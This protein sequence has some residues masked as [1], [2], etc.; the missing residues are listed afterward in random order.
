MKICVV[1]S[2]AL[3]QDTGQIQRRLGSVQGV[4]QSEWK[5]SEL[6]I[7][8]LGMQGEEKLQSVTHMSEEN[9]EEESI[10]HI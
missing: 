9:D 1:S 5:V 4:S 8:S 3:M 10:I 6:R 2:A 7:E